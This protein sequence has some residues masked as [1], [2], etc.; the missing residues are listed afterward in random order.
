[1][2]N[3]DSDK[4]SRLE[5]Q[6]VVAG[7]EFKLKEIFAVVEEFYT[8]VANDPV[9]KV[10]FQSVHDWPEHIDRLTH[11]W[12]IR[13]GGEPYMFSEYNPVMKHFFAGFNEEFLKRWLGMFHEVLDEKLNPEQSQFWKMLSHRMGQALNMR[14]EMLRKEYE[15]K[16]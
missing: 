8:R 13:F 14:N 10:P 4:K 15:E 16:S 11:F 2:K 1:M 7:V 3:D 12:W 5:D 9:L 6:L